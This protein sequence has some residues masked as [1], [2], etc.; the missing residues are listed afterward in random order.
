MILECSTLLDYY[1]CKDKDFAS[2]TENR[3]IM[4]WPK[5]FRQI[6]F[7]IK[8]KSFLSLFLFVC[9][10][11][12]GHDSYSAESSGPDRV[13]LPAGISAL[14]LT[15]ARQRLPPAVSSA[16]P[17]AD[18]LSSSLQTL[19][20]SHLPSHVSPLIPN[21]GLCLC[22]YDDEGVWI[23]NLDYC[24][25]LWNFGCVAASSEVFSFSL[26]PKEQSP[27]E[28]S[29]DMGRHEADFVWKKN[30]ENI[31]EVFDFMEELGS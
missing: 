10:I 9:Q 5:L 28:A 17:P 4:W 26:T 18:G 19:Q 31:H 16:R 12:A 13:L 21:E 8:A 29:A 25:A 1:S 20:P 6:F 15:S 27:A 30:T 7:F 24:K 11:I 22:D 23:L 14:T 3:I 2:Q